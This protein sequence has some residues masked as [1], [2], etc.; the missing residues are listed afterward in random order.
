MLV[1][2]GEGT[3]TTCPVSWI[4]VA[5]A[6]MKYA[7]PPATAE[8]EKA[9]ATRTRLR[10][11]LR[12]LRDARARCPGLIPNGTGDHLTGGRAPGL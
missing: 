7:K 2:D 11:G 8:R 6:G 5:A 10:K 4:A 12:R 1:G 3:L 9:S